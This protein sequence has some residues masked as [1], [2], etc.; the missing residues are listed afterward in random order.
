MEN[1]EQLEKYK[2]LL[3]PAVFFLVVVVIGLAILKPKITGIFQL[4]KQIS[5]DKK[6]LA[7]VTQKVN[8]LEGL[9]E[10]ELET[11]SEKVL[12]VLPSKK[13]VASLLYTL[14]VLSQET[15]VVVKSSKVSPG[16]L[17]TRSAQPKT[18]SKSEVPL[19]SFSLTIEGEREKIRNFFDRIETTLPL[20]KISLIDLSQTDEGLVDGNLELAALF[21]L[22]PEEL[23]AIEKPL[24]LIISQEEKAYQEL[25]RFKEVKK[26]RLLPLIPSG[27]ENLFTF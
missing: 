5:E 9:D 17:S 15:E 19:M 18:K 1:S 7:Q 10:V 25:A 20:M 4:R 22:L 11:K 3:W 13:N 27:K 8:A 21:L 26:A 24:E 12:K 2:K 6:K 16:E 14:K 23:G